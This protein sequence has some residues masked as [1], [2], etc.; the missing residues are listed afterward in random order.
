[1]APEVYGCEGY[2]QKADVWSLG[3]VMYEMAC[4]YDVHDPPLMYQ[5]LHRNYVSFPKHVDGDI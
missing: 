1:M 4:L 5:L 3:C 2:N